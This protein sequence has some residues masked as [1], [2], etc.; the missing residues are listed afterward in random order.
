MFGVTTRARGSSSARMTSMPSSSSSGSPLVA[1]S[2]GSTTTLR[3]FEFVDGGSDRFDNRRRRQHAGLRGMELDIA[4]NGLDLC[5]HEICH[6]RFDRDDA[7][8]VLRR[9]RRDRARSVH[10]ERREC[11]Q[12][13]LNA[14]TTARITAGDGQRAI[15]GSRH[16]EGQ[17]SATGRRYFGE[18]EHELKRRDDLAGLQFESGASS[19]A[20]DRVGVDAILGRRPG[21]A[22]AGQE[23]GNAEPPCGLSDLATFFRN[24]RIASGSAGR[25]S[26]D[27]H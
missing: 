20:D 6:Q 21:T 24:V 5:R 16:G 18:H 15:N 14:R 19:G 8:R 9:D 10:A 27:T 7:E 4:G 1:I 12:V 3:Q 23:I 26:R 25:P 13:R 22:A 17:L 2:T 11:L